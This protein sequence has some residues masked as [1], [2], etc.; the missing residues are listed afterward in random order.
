MYYALI[1]APFTSGRPGL[2]AELLNEVIAE[3][4]VDANSSKVQPGWWNKADK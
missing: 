4:I 2:G 1:G 3:F